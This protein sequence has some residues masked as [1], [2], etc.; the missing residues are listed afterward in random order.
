[1]DRILYWLF[2]SHHGVYIF[3][4]LSGFLICR[5]SL[6]QNFGYA[7]FVTKRVKRV[8]PAF[9]L[10]LI[11]CLLL[12]PWM[13][14]PN[15]NLIVF[16]QNLFFL[17]GVPSL[18]VPGIV[19]NNVTWSLFYEMVFY[20]FFPAVVFVSKS[21]SAPVIPSIIFCGVV[22]AYLPSVFGFYTEFF[23]FLFAGA[24]AGAL[25]AEQAR[26]IADAFSGKLII[27]LYLFVTTIFTMG[28]IITSQ[29]V[30]LFAG[31][32]FVIL[33]KIIDGRSLIA[34]MIAWWPLAALGRISYSFYLLHS[35]VIS[36]AF[37][38]WWKIYIQAGG[39]VFNGAFI[40][41]IAFIGSVA[42]A[43][44]SYQ[45]SER[46]YFRDHA[47]IDVRGEQQTRHA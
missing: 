19:F 4:M 28:Y 6:R 3:F 42:L 27:I 25:S 10:A 16:V 29:F 23:F 9:L 38:F 13:K 24:I 18:G 32:I 12:G 33:C 35:V 30:F 11:V 40:G 36:L 20:I 15:P 14:I 2:H 31:C 41:V 8:Y 39:S 22:I 47:A 45:L 7:E 26:K 1:M 21:Y 43:W 17:N 46:F 34:K 44:V 5:L 37:A